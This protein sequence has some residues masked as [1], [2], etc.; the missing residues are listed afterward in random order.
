[1]RLQDPLDDVFA[2]PSYVKA[3]RAL[4]RLPEGLAVSGRDLARRAGISHR[5]A[6]LALQSLSDQGLVLV[7]RATNARYYEL[8]R[9]HAM[10]ERLTGVF[11]FERQLLDDLA[12]TLRQ[13]LR[14]R[15]LPV[16]AVYLFGSASRGAMDVASDLDLLAV[17]Q[18]GQRTRVE[19]A[20]DDVGEALRA[21]YGNHVGFMVSD[22]APAERAA[23]EPDAALWQHIRDEARELVLR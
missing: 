11:A 6:D 7:R 21:R 1:M 8:N 23:A 15:R 18:P 13:E 5:T 16:T 10:V 20:L 19:E 9:R 22:S 2:A 3:L 4:F 12:A 17:C 14:R